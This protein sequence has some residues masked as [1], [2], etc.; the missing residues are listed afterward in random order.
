MK[1]KI[2]KNGP[3]LVSGGIPLKRAL[4]IEDEGVLT[5]KVVEEYK[6]GESYA[7]CRC[8]HSKN[9]PFCDGSHAKASFDGTE[10]AENNT[11]LERAQLYEGPKLNLLDDGR[12]SYAR[13]CHH[14]HGEA[15]SLIE[16]SDNP[17]LKAEAVE[18]SAKC[19]AGRLTAV[20]AD[21]TQLEPQYLPEIIVSED[22]ELRVSSPLYIRGSIPVEAAAGDVY[23]VRN[24]AALCRCG[25]SSI[26][27]FCDATHVRGGFDDG[28]IYD[29]YSGPRPPEKKDEK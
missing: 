25:N 13:F 24:R 21:G 29:Y 6:V 12:C 5:L 20:E 9:P 11:Y 23:E 19:P 4:V 14:H 17:L 10:S 2:S 18:A 28:K 16:E 26:K 15:W 27:P 22:V 8:G 1:I 3:Y 7:L